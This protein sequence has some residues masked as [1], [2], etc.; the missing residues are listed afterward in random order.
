MSYNKGFPLQYGVSIF[1]EAWETKNIFSEKEQFARCYYALH[2]SDWGDTK[3]GK[4][5]IKFLQT[6]L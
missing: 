6:Y 2:L 3:Q 5:H 1:L 4:C